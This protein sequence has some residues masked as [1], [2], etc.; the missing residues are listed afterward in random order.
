MYTNN[1]EAFRD[2]FYTA[3][4]KYLKKMPLEPVESALCDIIS[5][6]PEYHDHLN[7]KAYQAENYEPEENPFIHMSLHQSIREQLKVNRPAGIRE[8]KSQLMENYLD[9][10]TVEHIM[11]EC[12]A[13]ILWQAQQKGIL[14]SEEEY[15]R[16]LKTTL[17]SF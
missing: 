17:L 8:I 2:A 12:L 5:I 16:E 14:P 9:E 1:R 15:M 10:H 6:H 13:K 4:Q 3:W 7:S 11:M